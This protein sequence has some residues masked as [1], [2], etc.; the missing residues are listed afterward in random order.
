M[1]KS[2]SVSR[3]ILANRCLPVVA[4]L[5]STVVALLILLLS[6]L[7]V[8]STEAIPPT[9]SVPF[10]DIVSPVSIAPGSTGVTITIRGTGFVATSVVRWNGTAL[11]T[12]FVNAKELTA[13]VP[14]SFVAAVGLGNITVVSPTPGG[15][16]SNV[17]YLPV[18]SLLAGTNFPATPSSSVG[19]GNGPTGLATGDFNGD[20]KIDL[21]VTNITDATV[22]ILLGN[23]D[24]TFTA[25]TPI[26]VGNGPNWLV[27]GDFNEDGKLDLA[28]VNSTDATV[29][30]LLGNGDGTFTLHSSP[31]TG[32]SPFAIAAGDFN[33]DGHLDL[34]VTNAGDGTVSILLGV[35]DGTFTAAAA[36]TVGSLPQVLVV[37]DF[38]EDGILD[39]AVAN[40][41]SNTVSLLLGNGNGTFQAQT[42]TA[43]G[44]SGFPL[45]LI[46][47]DFNGDAHLD[48][49]AVNV[50]DVA[51]LLG[52]GA[53]VLTL[54]SN[55]AAGTTLISG[56]TGDY[57]GDGILD[58]VVADQALGE[59]FL[60]PGNG[61]GTFGSAIT[62][63]IASGTF[64]VATADFNGD[65]ALDL[66]FT[67]NGAASVSIFLQTL[68][69]SLAPA[70]LSFA[71]QAVGT[72][73]AQ[74]VVTLTNNS[75][76]TLSIPSIAISGANAGDYS[77]TNTCGATVAA[78]GGTCTITVTFTPASV[79]SSVATLSVT[80][81]ASNSPQTLALSGTGVALPP[82]ISKSFGASSIP[83]NGSTSLGFTVSN[84]NSASS[85]TG[86]AFTDALPAG[87][88]VATPNNLASSCTGTVTAVAGSSS[89]SLAGGALAASAPCSI[90][91]D[92]TGTI[93]GVKNNSVQANS[94]EGGAGSVAVA[95]V[96]VAAPPTIAKS[97]SPTIIPLSGGDSTLTFVITNSNATILVTG[98]AFTDNLPAGVVV[99]TLPIVG[100]NCGGI[101]T[102]TPGASVISLSGAQVGGGGNCNLSVHVTGTA[103]GNHNNTTGAVTSIEGG[104]G[105]SSNTATLTVVAPPS[106]A[107]AFGAAAIPLN[108][109]TSLTLTVT[110]P[111]ANTVP[112]TGVAFTDTLPTGLVVATPN[113]LSNT[114]G[115]TATAV[116][117][118][119][120]IS[121]TAASIATPNTSCTVV[122]NV[123]GTTA[124]AYT[125]TTGSIS[126]TNGGTGNTATANLNVAAPPAIT[127]AFGAASI[128][129]N[130]STSLTFTVT[131]PN[132][133]LALTGVAFTDNLPAGV[134]V[135]APNGLTSTCGGTSTA[136]AGSSTVSLSSGTLATSASCTVAVNLTG[137]T[138]G[139]K[140][141]SV[142]VTSTEG[143][144]GNTSNASITVVA[145]PVI[146]KA[147][148]A[149][150]IPLNGSTSLTFTIQNNNTTSTLSG[151]GFSDTLPAGLVVSTP[152]GLAG[153]CGGGTITSTQ[154]TNV[155]SLTGATL[156]Q[157][158]SCTFSVNV[159][160]TTGGTKNNST[161]N[162]TSTEGGTGGTASASINVV[163]PPSI[164]KAFGA[165][166]ISLNGT[167]SLT[168][169]ITNPVANAVA[170]TGVAFTDALPVGIVVATPN[171]LT[172]TCGGVGTA[173]AGSGSV[174]LTAGTIAASSTCTVS[175]NV[176]GTVSG[177]YTNTTST[178]TSTN[179]GTGNT[180]TANLTVAAPPTITKAF[181][182]ASVPLN[183]STS[184][185]FTVTNPN[186][187]VA[188][189]GIA[190]TD[191]LPAGV[192]VATPNGLTS[193][194]GGTSTAVAGASAL[195]L[196]SGTLA[197]SASCVISLNVTGTTPGV[198]NNSVQITSTEGGTGNTSN[199]SV[200]V[201]GAPVIIKAF[202]AASVPLNGSTSLTFTIQNNN[203]TSSL[204]G[205]GFSDT[206]PAGL[207]ISTPNG[208]SGTCGGGT[209]TSTQATNVVSLTGATL[210]QSTSCTFAVNVT[211]TS[212]GTKNN[213]T[214][215]VT[216]TEG[217]TGGTASASINVVAPPSIAK[218]FGAAAIS[219]NG[220]TSLTFTIT[221]P[222]A[223][224]VAETGV[225]FTDALP[226]GIVVAT[227]NG[228]INTCGG[229]GTA[230]AGSGNVLLAGGTIASS[231][232]CTL[233]VNVTGTASGSFTNTTG[234][235][236]STNGGTG[237]TA[238][239]NLV[240]ATPPTIT[241]A[242]GAAS[243]PLNGATSL[244]FTVTNPAANT[245]S[246]TGVAF[247]D[248]LPAGLVVATPNALI[249]TCGGA[250][251]AAA[252]GS[253]ASLSAA[254]L[255]PN[256][257]CTLSANVTGTT[258]GVKNNSVQVTSIE[259]GTGNTS[260]ASVTVVGAPVIIKVFGAASIPLNGATS[261]SFTIQNNNTTS[262]LSGVGFSDTLPAGLVISTPNGLAGTCGGGTIT[263]TQA[264]NVVSLTG[265]TLA[266]SSSCTFSVNITGTAAGTQNNTTGAVTSTEGGTGGTA[267]ASITV[268]APPSI[269]KA[270]GAASIPLNGTTSL[271]LTVTNP[272]AN[273]AALTGVAFTDALPA[274]IVV[275][276]PNGL[277]NTCGGVATAVAG[278]GSVSLTAGTAASSSSCA[279]TVN[280]TGTASGIFTNTT[281]SVSSTNGGTGNTATANLTVASPPTITKTFS[282]LTAPLNGATTLTFNIQ[283]P[284]AGVLLTGVAFT[285]NLPAGLVVATPNNLNSTCGG[286]STAATGSSSV[287]LATGTLAATASCTVSVHVTG[288]TA[289]VKNNSVQVSSTEGGIG[290]T[291][292]ASITVVAPPVIIK[293]FGAATVPLNGSTSLSFTIQN[294]NTTSTLSGI[295]FSDTLPA[296]LVISTPNGLAG[297]CGGGTIT[298]TQATN[299]ISLSGATLAQSSSCTFSVNTTG[300]AAG[301]Q[302][303]TTGTVTSTEGGTG[304]TAS[305]T[306]K[307]LGPPSIAKAFNPTGI[308]LNGTTSLTFT[309]TNP[310]ANT[311]ALTGIAFTDTL[312]AGLAVANSVATVC[313]G[314]LTVTAPTGISLAAAT[315]AAS[316]QC[317]FSV[318]VTGA[319]AGSYTNTTGTVSS[320]NGGAGN[321]ASANLTVAAP[322][323]ISKAFGAATIPFNGSTSLSFTITNP[324]STIPLTGVAFTDTLPAG[325]VVST[326]NGVAGACGAGT[327]TATAASGVVSLAAGTLA[328]SASC[329]FSV[330]V[331]GTTAGAKAN[332]TAAVSSTESGAGA[333]SNTATVTVLAPPSITKVF[334]AAS[335][336]LA[337]GT[338]LTF[339]ITNSNAAN[340]L[341]GVAVT[342]TLPAGLVVSTPNGLS[343]ACGAGTITA[344]AG[345]NSV[346][347]T[348]GTIA[349]SAT[350][351]FAVNVTS[352]VGGSQVNTTGT[353]ASTNGGAGN[354]ATAT[355]T[356]L[357]PDL[358]IAK[359]HIGNFMQGQ[360][361]ALYT[362]TVSNG[363]TAATSGTVT[364]TDTLPSSLT[365][366][367]IAG[368]GWTCTL[369]TLTCT[370]ADVL[371]ISGTYPPLTLIVN[372]SG[373]APASATNTATVSGGGEVN[374]A[375][376][377]ASDV[378][379]IDVVPQDFS[380]VA[381]PP[382][383]TV[384][385]GQKADFGL[386]L[387]PLNNVPFSTA[388][389]LS[390]TGVPTNTTIVFQPKTVTPGSSA[391]TDAFIIMTSANDPYV[392]KNG[393]GSPAPL[394][395]VG[396]PLAGILFFGIGFRRK[397]WSNANSRLGLM[398]L[399]VFM[400]FALYGCASATR[401]RNLGTPPGVYTI[402]V[403]GAGT[404]ATHST[405]VT[406]TVTP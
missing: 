228:L 367:A 247:T 187:T 320:T 307:V 91:V 287:T 235:V 82:S 176:T 270:F 233:V 10:V 4:A 193:T 363:G 6:T 271:T 337:S 15:G 105:T 361:G 358:T 48:V 342:D 314:T 74:Q 181:G 54:K 399:F 319:V 400:G 66:A 112:E 376:D 37:G 83:L 99:A 196:A 119:T 59:A 403:T 286:T 173:V 39:I 274:G 269:A 52:N 280:V 378:T 321:T 65:G 275:A 279:L 145:P 149:A 51:I 75:G 34:A 180:G 343:G 210:A 84:P 77:E 322:P 131:N 64:S 383:I 90:S 291:S 359:S 163:G 276:T 371:A 398:L 406:L 324:N 255:A 285:D 184:L 23:G 199:A 79:G 264:T 226:A 217:G 136:V 43:V 21:A 234:T 290:N 153:T 267:S 124:G 213:T 379:T 35:G 183:G 72:P 388:I 299:V 94:I 338:S 252:G 237:N 306:L 211:G 316:G 67:N 283:N 28:V 236:T 144:T 154:A 26:A 129:L 36:P 295:A 185:S 141:N 7:M 182:A 87:L 47:G 189:T 325:L 404:G 334:G 198:K 297:T 327:I 387:T 332:T 238:T 130:G 89:V 207:V 147:F 375:N 339:T 362:I 336:P 171:G 71:P 214:G 143:G 133:I 397:N 24:G 298:A 282:A 166:T 2:A 40:Q 140:N 174:S 288:T 25:Q 310:A 348:G 109:T 146:I 372:V 38:N 170:E 225:A 3:H 202:G 127:K 9:N 93:A 1:E 115:G 11:T 118:S 150:S 76:S 277:T 104:T 29:S 152:N 20:G 172:N 340:G 292:N 151:V 357:A 272:A 175:V 249:N 203:T 138:A 155:V 309:I 92:I 347:L 55:P 191:N 95:S 159:T 369:G 69:V 385:A 201:V 27:T 305:A 260:N 395:A 178:V 289:G 197:T 121:L 108:G 389:T 200:T 350:C 312:P 169:T 132:T 365:A 188:L 364:V 97:F 281:G 19:V 377:S 81:S 85:L 250:A 212:A 218:A 308:A 50:T 303:N 328:A 49:A 313:G 17:S 45:G 353:V 278:S 317:V 100:S 330:N 240:V 266:L 386:T 223:N 232:N 273:T 333:V 219:L 370:R 135:T 368:T 315:A 61:D 122:V 401:F 259:G 396:M 78:N 98:V 261:L 302:N 42:T 241:K 216:S 114:C 209:I 168:F 88:V 390:S 101:V 248:N 344:A 366:T 300:T 123:T 33:A 62:F 265:A 245:I 256:T 179:G 206:L 156:A 402:T 128:P 296:G 190:F 329:T 222:A 335:V 102:A 311:A 242:F 18:A 160:G 405:T 44:G 139:V 230:V 103:A 360:T 304:G 384:K 351:T 195:S 215:N 323:T 221:N 393:T 107:K 293:A 161:G 243:I 345:A 382:A 134:V 142:Q 162:V 14:D 53:G 13:T 56:V 68:P 164:A 356:V 125:N 231:A 208:L 301:D 391:A 16:T 117:G 244:T 373:T 381:A 186:T 41:S 113:G 148:G 220:T 192:V 262:A 30:I 12:T 46:A 227:P 86:I 253:S 5:R 331:T 251:T 177:N 8:V 246:L 205:T 31:G 229:V 120:A 294:N 254:T 268:L 263:S 106:I 73:S 60:F 204:T 341:T 318:T 58:I 258:A 224:A 380:I 70:S 80:D 284:N 157:S 394:F 165:A 126:S 137:T 158:S 239:A 355:L 374:A 32:A 110:N 57:N 63:T 349:A 116:A 111:A 346:T 392:T 326:P 354:T 22:S 257:S 167:T 194:C 96:T 352:I